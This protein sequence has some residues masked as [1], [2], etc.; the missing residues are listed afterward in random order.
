LDKKI[1]DSKKL[2]KKF[3]HR[4]RVIKVLSKDGKF[5]VTAI[6]N[7]N[8][9][10][11]AQKR[12]NLPYPA[13]FLLARA[14]SAASMMA[15]FLKGEER[16]TIEIEGKGLVNYIYAEA[17]QVGEVRGFTEFSK[18][19]STKTIS[20]FSELLSIGLLRVVRIL[21][22]EKEPITSVIPLQKGDIQTDLAYYYSQ[23][24][25]IPTAI[26]LDADFDDNGLIKQS[27]GIFLQAMPG[28]S[29]KE[30]KD[31]YKLLKNIPP[32]T[33]YLDKE[34]TP[35]HILKDI[36][37]FDYDLIA[38]TPVDFYCRCSKDS[39]MS[40]LVT[41][42]TSEIEQMQKE[43]N[44]ELVCRYCNAKYYL[45]DNDFKKLIEET[46]ARRN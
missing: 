35:N 12:H 37:P 23:S 16:V 27:G 28:T 46:K 17:L 45:N 22:N 11:T 4:D 30:I 32:L 24:E 40:K 13:A 33:E 7:S 43:G 44:N 29:E 2:I 20:D 8:T 14:L 36:L 38:S 18:E 34:S 26:I 5:R 3:K 39:F 42:K 1:K 15:S 41:L 6:K 31:I 9:A 21:Y 19:L 25:Q 10:L